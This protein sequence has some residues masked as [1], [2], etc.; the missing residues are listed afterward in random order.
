LYLLL[1]T[2]FIALTDDGYDEVHKY[3]VPDYQNEEPEEP[4]QD[5]E[6]LGAF[7]D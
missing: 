3:Y 5:F 6:F 7:N 1:H 4:C 2:V